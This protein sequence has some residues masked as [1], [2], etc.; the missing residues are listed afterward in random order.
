MFTVSQEERDLF[1]GIGIPSETRNKPAPHVQV[2]VIH[3][4]ERVLRELEPHTGDGGS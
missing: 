4:L 1:P 3:Y 2:A